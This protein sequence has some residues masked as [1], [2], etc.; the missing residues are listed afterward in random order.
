MKKV[1]Y[2]S[3]KK[4]NGNTYIYLRRSYRERSKVKHEYIYSFGSMPK[5]LEKMYWYRENPEKF[6]KEL[7]ERGYNLKD[8]YEWIMTME[9]KVTSTGREFKH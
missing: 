4:S 5:A 2:L 6:P 3:R 9:T 7:E 8:L 1:G